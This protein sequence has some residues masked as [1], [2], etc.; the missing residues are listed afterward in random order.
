MGI[1]VPIN[2]VW[3]LPPPS[4]KKI[5]LK[6]QSA[7]T[8]VWNHLESADMSFFLKEVAFDLREVGLVCR[9]EC[10]LHPTRVFR[11]EWALQHQVGSHSEM[12][13]RV[14]SNK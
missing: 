12:W 1:R 2:A 5:P 9:Q 6:V 10:L 13:D 4:P 14:V 3:R 8:L 7:Q 11:C